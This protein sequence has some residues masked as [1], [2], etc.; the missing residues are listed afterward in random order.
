MK[1]PLAKEAMQPPHAP[2]A[3]PMPTVGSK[4]PSRI[5]GRKVANLP[6]PGVTAPKAGA[7]PAHVADHEI[8]GFKSIASN[9]TAMPGGRLALSEMGAC[10]L[11]RKAEHVGTCG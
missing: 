10:G 3:A 8:R 2:S 9:P 4:I 11:C 5:T 1:Q 6:M 7:T